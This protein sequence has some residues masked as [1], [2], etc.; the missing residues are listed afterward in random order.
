MIFDVPIESATGGSG[1]KMDP[2]T[3]FLWMGETDGRSQVTINFTYKGTPDETKIKLP[4]ETK[5]CTFVSVIGRNLNLLNL[6]D[7]ETELYH[8]LLDYR[9]EA[10]QEDSYLPI[11]L[12]DQIKSQMHSFFVFMNGN[13]RL[14]A[15]SRVLGMFFAKK[16]Q[17]YR[18]VNL[19]YLLRQRGMRRNISDLV[20]FCFDF[21]KVMVSW[22]KDKHN[23]NLICAATET[24]L[25]ELRETGLFGC[26]SA[27]AFYAYCEFGMIV[28]CLP[29]VL[30]ISEDSEGLLSPFNFIFIEYASQLLG[31]CTILFSFNPMCG[32]KLTRLW[33]SMIATA[34]KMALT[35]GV[36]MNWCA[37]RIKESLSV[38]RSVHQYPSELARAIGDIMTLANMLHHSKKPKTT[39]STARGP[40]REVRQDEDIQRACEY[41][42]L[43]LPLFC[44]LLA[45]DKVLGWSL[46]YGANEKSDLE[47][48]VERHQKLE[49]HKRDYYKTFID[50][51]RRA[52]AL[53]S[54][55]ESQQET[56]E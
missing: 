32:G 38:M 46:W 28:K 51:Y 27:I 31:P 6:E 43:N 13:F 50:A 9:S 11:E 21:M 40:R 5:P 2:I 8:N 45:Y 47:A 44:E 20:E 4:L 52:D 26:Y 3:P 36:A 35:W 30:D 29:L 39:K 17:E 14:R 23:V 37:M 34:P 41:Q 15:L 18:L 25:D 1:P 33:K 55:D 54:D 24:V 16:K 12:N 19:M 56:S 10:Q 48:F 42:A 49:R 53:K 7:L 22:K